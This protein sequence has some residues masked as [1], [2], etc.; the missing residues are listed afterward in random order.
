MSDHLLAT[1]PEH[2]PWYKEVS[3]GAWRVLILAG[4]GWLF[5][6]YEI[7]ILSLTIPAFIAYFH[8]TRAD[9]G[10]IGSVSAAGLI[11]GGIAFGWIADRI[12]RV[13]TLI[14]AILI[15][16]I[17]SGACAFAGNATWIAILRFAAGLGMGGAWTAG[18]ALVAE[19]WLPQHRGKGGA[20]M[21]LGLPLGSLLGIGV[22]A[23]ASTLLGGLDTGGWRWVYAVGALPILI[24][25]PIAR[26]TPESPVWLE[27]SSGSKPRGN[28]SDLLHREN[29]VGLAKA[30]GFIFFVQYIYWAVFA[31]T[32]TFLVAV[33]HFNFV[34]SLVFT[35]AQ[36]F[37]SLIGFVIF[38]AL[39]DRIGRKATFSIYLLIGA[40]AIIGFVTVEQ[41][42]TLLIASFFTGLGITGLFAGM[43][44]FAAELVPKTSARGF[45]MGL[46]YNGGRIGGM[47]AP[48]LIGALATSASGFKT[49]M[50]TTIVAFFLAW[51]VVL[52]SPETKGQ[53]LS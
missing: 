39:V 21:Q 38:A 22:V 28:I 49:G 12:G 26:R 19:T 29:A 7:F 30:F 17:F 33:K 6:V 24:L 25:Y 37:G 11:I 14:L 50:L 3:G 8:L 53:A 5:E 27:R 48:V 52:I 9:A 20:L 43:G 42:S 36:Q 18:A 51:G 31:W 40:I 41:E 47:I 32:P 4:L 15:Y 45:A 1:A 2:T 44:P 16:S 23:A 35:L 46:A 34:H 13:R 10:L